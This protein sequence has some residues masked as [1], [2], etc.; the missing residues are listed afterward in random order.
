MLFRSGRLFPLV[1]GTGVHEIMHRAMAEIYPKYRP[2]FEIIAQDP[3]LKYRWGGTADAYVEIDG[4][5]W[6]LDYKTISGVGLSFLDEEPKE[7]HVLQVSA[8]YHFGPYKPRTAVL[9]LPSS[10]NYKNQWEEPRF[11]EFEPVP[12]GMLLSRM[13]HVEASIAEW[14]LNQSLPDWPV[15]KWEWKTKGRS[16]TYHLTYKP[17]YTSI[18]CPWAGTHDDPCG[19]SLQE[20]IIAGTYKDG[21]LNI[22]EKYAIIVDEIGVP[23]DA[24]A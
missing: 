22:D 2:E 24:K 10:G 17:H 21:D 6:L 3:D 9:Y 5:L 13:K 7:D 12:I 4:D 1:Q 8:Y 16:K 23:D 15:G 11:V 14:T 20:T 19:C 18:F